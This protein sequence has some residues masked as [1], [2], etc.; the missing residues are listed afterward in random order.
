MSP[1]NILLKS[2]SWK[3]FEKLI[4]PLNKTDKGFCFAL[5]VR[6]LTSLKSRLLSGPRP[7]LKSK[8][9]GQPLNQEKLTGLMK[10]GRQ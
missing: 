5:L 6:N 4:K 3:E 9:N 1:R 7:I 8:K 10:N 2:N